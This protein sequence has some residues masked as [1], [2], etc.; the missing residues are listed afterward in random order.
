MRISRCL[1]AHP[2]KQARET[3]CRS[4][5]ADHFTVITYQRLTIKMTGFTKQWFS[6]F[7]SVL[8]KGRE[9]ANMK[10][11]GDW[12]C[13]G[14]LNQNSKWS[15]SGLG[16]KKQTNWPTT[17]KTTLDTVLQGKVPPERDLPLDTS[18]VI[19]RCL[20]LPGNWRD[21]KSDWLRVASHKWMSRWKSYPYAQV[22]SFSNT[23]K[24]LEAAV[25][26]KRS[27]LV[28]DSYGKGKCPT[29][30]GMN[31]NKVERTGRALTGSQ[32]GSCTHEAMTLQESCGPVGDHPQG[33]T[34]V[35]RCLEDM[36]C[37]ERLYKLG[38]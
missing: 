15:I 3:W 19:L 32:E 22:N 9:H 18:P 26:H 30:T 38:W 12:K 20:Y 8:R 36:N 1:T 27:A 21:P 14:R 6:I 25:D 11:S 31:G 10:L 4:A 28:S 2:Y 37:V 29:G 34:E 23:E 35:G 7:L 17:T 33:E 24:A 16:N 5:L 13:V